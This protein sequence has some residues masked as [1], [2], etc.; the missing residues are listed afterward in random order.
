MCCISGVPQRPG[1][2]SAP[3]I[4]ALGCFR[5]PWATSAILRDAAM[6]AKATGLKSFFP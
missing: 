6:F 4:K 1:K 3:V 5:L 2:L